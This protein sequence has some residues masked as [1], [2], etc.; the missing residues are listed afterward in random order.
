MPGAARS[1]VSEQQT[2]R[3]LKGA[4]A[5][6]TRERVEEAACLPLLRARRLFGQGVAIAVVDEGIHVESLLAKLRAAP[7]MDEG[8]FP[9]LDVENSTVAALPEPF[10]RGRR[11][12]GSMCAYDACLAA[13]GCTLLEL[14]THA[15]RAVGLMRIHLILAAYH[16][17]NELARAR[18]FEHIVVINAW[19]TLPNDAL[20]GIEPGDPRH[21][22]YQALCELD[23]AG[24]DVIFSAPDHH[25]ERIH[26]PALHPG[27]LTVTAVNLDGTPFDSSVER[28]CP[29]SGKPDVASYQGFAGYELFTNQGDYGT[30]AAAALCAGLVAAVRSDGR[31]RSLSPADLRARFRESG[32]GS[33]SDGIGIADVGRVLARS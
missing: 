33:T 21:P 23:A 26:G 20:G 28:L 32:S 9:S 17:L 10:A 14:P 13:P 12:H 5:S 31:A 8:P 3:L 24:V 27:V 25:A 15:P 19:Q 11:S 1:I 16:H 22:L 18:R 7:G 29:R 2:A 4:S 30:S 6:A